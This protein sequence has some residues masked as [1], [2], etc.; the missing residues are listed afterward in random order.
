[1]KSGI[2]EIVNTENQKRYIGSATDLQQRFWVHKCLLRNDNHHNRHLQ[3]AWN[4]Y[5]EDC[6]QFNIIKKVKT[7]DLIEAEQCCLD[8]VRPEYNIAPQA[9]NTLGVKYTK[10]VRRKLTEQRMGE[11]NHFYGRKHSKDTRKKMGE[12]QL[13]EENKQAKLTTEKVR[14]IRQMYA[15]GTTQQEIADMFNISRGHVGNVVLMKTWK[16]VI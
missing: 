16:H 2:Y 6:F 4:K 14:A 5:G 15:E 3:R 1:M 8:K 13:G 9:G 10:E 7:G 12:W 11:K